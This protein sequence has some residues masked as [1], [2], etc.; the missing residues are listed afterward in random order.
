M[1]SGVSR[2]SE[3]G[4]VR[5]VLVILRMGR[6]WVGVASSVSNTV[7]VKI[8]FPKTFSIVL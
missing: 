4:G 5:Y 8:T 6:S 2:I 1:C 7:R 3:R